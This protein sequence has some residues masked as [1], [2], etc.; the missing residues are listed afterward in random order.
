MFKDNRCM[1]STLVLRPT[2][3]HAKK[4]AAGKATDLV[5]EF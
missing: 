1:L 4:S 2:K 3:K 5:L